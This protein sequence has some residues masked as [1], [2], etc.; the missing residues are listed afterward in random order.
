MQ[1]SPD[2]TDGG[3][4]EPEEGQL[5]EEPIIKCVKITK[6]SIKKDKKLQNYIVQES[7]RLMQTPSEP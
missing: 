4:S 2:T 7:A 6:K 5:P 3:I 1:K